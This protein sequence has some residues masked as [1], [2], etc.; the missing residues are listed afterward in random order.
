MNKKCYFIVIPAFN[1]GATIRRIVQKTLRYSDNIIVVDDGSVDDTIVQIADLPITILQNHN[2]KGK[3]ATLMRGFKHALA[4]GANAIISLDG[5]GQHDADNI[6]KL[7]AAHEQHQHK[8]IIGA[9][10]ENNEA[11]PSNRLWANHVAD[12]WVSWAAGHYVQDS[13]SGFRL[14]PAAVL[15]NTHAA[16]GKYSS[17]VFETAIIINAAHKGFTTNIIAIKSCY[18]KKRRKSHYRPWQDITKVV[19]MITVKLIARGLNIPGLI[20]SQQQAHRAKRL[21]NSI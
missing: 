20:R 4:N 14:Y 18:P 7:I 2:N 5:D 11:A 15:K 12:F 10:L 21:E 13:Q 1:E 3:A 17:F 9:R 6:P 16:H 19:L 8:L